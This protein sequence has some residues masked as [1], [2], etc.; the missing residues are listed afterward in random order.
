MEKGLVEVIAVSLKGF[1][2]PCKQLLTLLL[3]QVEDVPEGVH[4][5]ID[6]AQSVEIPLPIRA[7]TL[8]HQLLAG[9]G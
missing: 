9:A 3:P 5:S 2:Q 1:D 8:R 7:P 4:D 6:A